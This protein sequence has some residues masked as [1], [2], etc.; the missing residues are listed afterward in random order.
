MT[1]SMLTMRWSPWVRRR[2]LCT[3][4]LVSLTFLPVPAPAVQSPGTAAGPFPGIITFRDEQ[5]TVRITAAPLRQVM[6]EISR[7]SGAQVRWLSQEGEDL[8]SVEFTAL[9]VTDALRRLLG[10][11]NFLLFY[12]ATGE[13]TKLT[14]IWISASGQAGNQPGLKSPPVPQRQ[15]TPLP[16]SASA[17]Q[18]GEAASEE[19]AE[20]EALPLETLLQIAR[21]DQNPSVRVEAIARL[22][23]YA[24]DD[25][26]VQVILSQVAQSDSNPQ[27]Q[28]AAAELLQNLE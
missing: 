10:G 12:T 14:Q 19:R 28:E 3:L 2:W 9:P 27:V 16:G 22:A 11:R 18:S 7:L 25:S 13:E 5:L 24:Q 15:T 26:R 8:T 4:L 17:P 1:G 21:L 20:L 23:G 6:G